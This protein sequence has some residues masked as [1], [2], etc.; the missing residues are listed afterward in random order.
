MRRNF[1]AT[2]T[3][4]ILI[5]MLIQIFPI[6]AW[7]YTD[8]TPPDPK[9][10][11]FGPRANN[12]LINLYFDAETEWDAL[13]AG[14]IDLTDWALTETYY[15]RFTTPPQSGYID[16]MF[17]GAE[18]GLIL[19]DINWNNNQFLCNPQDPAYPNPLYPNNPFEH[20]EA[21]QAIWHLHDK[22]T[23]LPI[24]VGPGFYVD[25]NTT[26]P[27][28]YGS[29]ALPSVNPYPYNTTQAGLLLDS[30][31]VTGDD[32]TGYRYYD[33]N[34]NGIY[35]GGDE[36]LELHFAIRSDHSHRLGI[37][38]LLADEMATVGLRVSRHYGPS[39]LLLEWWFYGKKAHF[40]TAG[41]SLGV[42]P[43]HTRFWLSDFYWHPGICYNTGYVNDPELDTYTYGTW[44]A[45]TEA[46][47]LTNCL[48]FQRRFCKI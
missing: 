27:P 16:S 43:Y 48:D 21:R 31:G 22:P 3:L 44:L 46:E 5:F 19:L 45:N 33:L 41:L 36:Y 47:A 9:F 25:L 30:I 40:Y 2:T 15:N 34:D 1:L 24:V 8:G 7:D 14:E 28:V 39:V 6:T 42:E 18:F 35:D 13:E 32:G 17:Y 23:W 37:A 4:L 20:A 38:D 26:H 12:L 10:E 29:F 11:Q